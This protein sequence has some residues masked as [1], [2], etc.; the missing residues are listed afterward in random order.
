MQSNFEKN[1]ES[2]KGSFKIKFGVEWNANP[3]LYLT[4]LQTMYL[5]SLAEISNSGLGQVLAIQGDCITILQTI[6]K[7]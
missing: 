6:L 1:F 3:Q 7:K 5:S 4:Y 2:H